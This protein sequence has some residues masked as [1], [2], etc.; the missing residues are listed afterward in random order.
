MTGIRNV[1]T[2]PPTHLLHAVLDAAAD[3]VLL[4]DDQG[5]ILLANAAARRLMPGLTSIGELTDDPDSF[6]REWHGRPLR[7]R[8]Q[9]VDEGHHVWTVHDCTDEHARAASL[10][11]ERERTAF[12]AEASRRLSASLHR[13]RCV[14]TTVE[15]A[16]AHLADAAVVVLPPSR[17]RVEWVRALTGSRFETGVMRERDADGVPGLSEALAGFP[18]VPSRWLDPAQVPGS[19]L[20]ADFGEIGALLVTPL[21]GNGVPAGALILARR[22]PGLFS[23]M[24]ELQARIFAARAGAAI[25]AAVLYQEQV[26]TTG[27][28]QADL[29]P[30]EL[31]RIEG[32]ELA[33]AYRPAKDAARIGGDFYDAFPRTP[34]LAPG[35]DPAETMVVLGDVCGKG[36]K[37]AVLAGKV[38][39]TL[40]ALRL[41]EGRP[42][43]LLRVLNQAL[44]DPRDRSRFVTLAL[45]S[46]VRD[47][48]G[49]RVTVASGGHPPPLILRASGGVEPVLARGT[50]IGVS[51]T[52][53]VETADVTLG[54][55]DLMLLYSDGLFEARG[56]AGGREAYGEDRLADSLGT[57]R[58]MPATAVVERLEQLVSDWINGAGHDDIAML[59]V[60]VPPRVPD[61]GNGHHH[62]VNLRR[63]R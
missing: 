28:L 29:L 20:P 7:G 24:E 27:I 57:C 13:G 39:Q 46:M 32:L 50:L 63:A 44:I 54:P 19:L 51:S 14:R 4:C 15:L 43:P 49:W 6:E 25:S 45:A 18:P 22:A 31:P 1:S 47:G 59:A 36:P 58:N 52:I 11:A 2:P 9:P 5:A 16:A 3:A 56:G 61:Y 26:E 60:R 35:A 33:G 53:T 8:R 12:L 23:E 48:D 55:G 30:P 41:L 34:S 38:R 62:A 17:H 37:A 21:P 40:R 10:A 42:D